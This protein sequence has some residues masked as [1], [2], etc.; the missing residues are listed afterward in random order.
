MAAL[1]QV[2]VDTQSVRNCGWYGCRMLTPAE[3]Y[4]SF[5][6]SVDGD[7]SMNIEKYQRETAIIDKRYGGPGP[8]FELAALLRSAAV[9]RHFASISVCRDV[10]R[11]ASEP[12]F[13][14]VTSFY[15]G[16]LEYLRQCARSL[17][18][19][20]R[21]WRNKHQEEWIVVNGDPLVSNAAILDVIPSS[22]SRYTVLLRDS[23]DS[24]LTGRLNQAI[25]ATHGEWILFVDADDL[26]MPDTVAILEHYIR[27]FPKCRYISSG[28]IDVDENSQ[29]LRHR[30]HLH[31]PTK[32]FSE[33]MIA[34]HLKAIRRDLFDDVGLLDSAFDLAQDYEFALRVA[35]S[36]PLLLL[37]DYL[38]C[39]RW[40]RNTQSVSRRD[41]QTRARDRAREST[42]LRL[43][44]KRILSSW[45]WTIRLR[46]LKLAHF[47]QRNAPIVLI[48]SLV[49]GRKVWRFFK[50]AI[51]TT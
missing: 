31:P 25:L 18:D 33:G 47:L 35:E 20:H 19:I 16:S 40:H 27:R 21:F 6:Q 29:I 11:S 41:N 51:R 48:C 38:Y 23:Q 43:T 4:N 42:V 46:S 10:A 49:V 44:T 24:G 28:I 30:L 5:S 22:L 39:Y 36:E 45:P 2:T 32:L 50:S 7:L 8:G 13:S 26:V 1:S 3:C 9:D 17:A 14:F 15:G 37:P 12:S 34:G